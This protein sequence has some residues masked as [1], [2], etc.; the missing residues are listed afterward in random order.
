MLMFEMV[1]MGE[2]S[3]CL[4]GCSSFMASLASGYL[5]AAVLT[6]KVHSWPK[7]VNF[8]EWYTVLYISISFFDDQGLSSYVF[9]FAR[10]KLW[11]IRTFS[12]KC[13]TKNFSYDVLFS[14]SLWF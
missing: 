1:W 13:Q 10:G 14:L 7:L 3:L 9:V 8:L 12:V 4:K 5:H 11:K 6:E 2:P